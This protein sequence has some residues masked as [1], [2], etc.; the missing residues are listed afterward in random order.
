MD[1]KCWNTISPC[2][3][4]AL[5]GVGSRERPA[6]KRP[7]RKIPSSPRLLAGLELSCV[8]KTRKDGPQEH[9]KAIQLSGTFQLADRHMTCN[10]APTHES[11]KNRQ[12][13]PARTKG[14]VEPRQA[15]L[16]PSPQED[17]PNSSRETLNPKPSPCNRQLPR[18]SGPRG[19]S[20]K[21]PRVQIG[22]VSQG[23]VDSIY[24][25]HASAR[26]K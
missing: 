15:M 25:R 13:E 16:Q 10:G 23:Q 5:A 4:A 12:E 7:H 17:I 14:L 18:V 11:E 6:H 8:K 21:A 19:P 1:S 24:R 26:I 22:P 20:F 2:S 3:Y 9:R